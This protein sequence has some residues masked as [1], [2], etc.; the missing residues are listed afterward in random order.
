MQ[1]GR[2][3]PMQVIYAYIAI[4]S[5]H[6][7]VRS[8]MYFYFIPQCGQYKGT[9]TVAALV[10]A[11]VPNITLY[12]ISQYCVHNYMFN[13]KTDNTYDLARRN[14]SYNVRYSLLYSRLMTKTRFIW[15]N[16]YS[17]YVNIV[18]SSKP[19]VII[20]FLCFPYT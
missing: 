16:N 12:I 4:S 6:C 5:S 2:N 11:Q 7:T 17:R 1:S 10:I 14:S 9:D 20:I 13:A 3:F 18:I 15:S 19:L 8:S